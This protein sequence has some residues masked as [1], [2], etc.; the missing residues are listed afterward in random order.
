MIRLIPFALYI[1]LIA[2]YEVALRDLITLYGA[3][4]SLAPLLVAL[5]ALYKSEL[6]VAWFGFIVGLVASIGSVSIF[7]WH[8]LLLAMLGVVA[9][10]VRERLN[11]ES[12]YS[13]LL[14]VLGVVLLHNLLWLLINRAEAFWPVA[15]SYG[16]A[17]ALFT[18]FAAWLFFLIKDGHLTLARIKSIF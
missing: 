11:V 18:T 2:L 3:Q 4:I 15:L 16:L 5:I 10:H 17:S 6:T 8:A 9:F 12:L 14:L 13:R 1:L 7:G